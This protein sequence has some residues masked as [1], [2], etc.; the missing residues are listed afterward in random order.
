MISLHF[1]WAWIL[2][3]VLVIFGIAFCIKQ[4]NESDKYGVGAAFGCAVLIVAILLALVLGGIFI[5]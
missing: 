5:W 1:H 4:S 2:M 3:A